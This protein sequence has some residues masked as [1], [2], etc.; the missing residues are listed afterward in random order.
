MT[1][2]MTSKEYSNLVN[3]L[4]EEHKAY[5]LTGN[6]KARAAVMLERAAAVIEDLTAPHGLYQCFHCCSPHSVLWN[7]DYTF[8]DYGYEGEG[9]V[10]CLQCMVCGA[11]IEYRIP[12]YPPA[13]DDDD[14]EGEEVRSDDII[15]T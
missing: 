13:D 11:E 6:A 7:C 1:G 3:A 10:Q 14:S 12:L 5:V 9:I 15:A 4:R 8:E 2:D